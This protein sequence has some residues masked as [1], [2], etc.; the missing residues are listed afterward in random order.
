MCSELNCKK[1]DAVGR[2]LSGDMKGLLLEVVTQPDYGERDRSQ[3]IRKAASR[4]SS[5]RCRSVPRRGRK[6]LIGR[7]RKWGD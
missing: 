3:I 5:E 1:T 2:S 6:L 7:C 4:G